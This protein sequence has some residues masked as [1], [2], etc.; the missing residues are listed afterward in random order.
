LARH[1][2]NAQI[3]DALFISTRTVETH[4]SAPLRKLQLP[5]PHRSRR[6]HTARRQRTRGLIKS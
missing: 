1:L 5:D 6:R 3:V 2:T 4:V